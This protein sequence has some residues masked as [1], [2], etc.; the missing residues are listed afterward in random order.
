MRCVCKQLL[1]D[2]EF[3]SSAL[4]G[5]ELTNINGSADQTSV[6]G[7]VDT[8][9]KRMISFIGCEE[10]CGYLWQWLRNVSANGGSGW[11]NYYGD[12]NFGQTHGSSYALLAG[13]FWGDGVSCGSRCRFGNAARSR[14]DA[15][16]GGRGSSKIMLY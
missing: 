1:S 15:G 10:M 12:N 9:S 6:G 14:V 11:S 13:G 16:V 3:T 7:H 5:N 4:G 2:E 8:L